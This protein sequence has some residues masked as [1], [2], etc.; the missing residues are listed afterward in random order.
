MVVVVVAV[1]AGVAVMM[2]V[3]MA[4]LWQ[5]AAVVLRGHGRGVGLGR[6]L[7]HELEHKTATDQ[8]EA[9]PP[10]NQNRSSS[11]VTLDIINKTDGRDLTLR[12]DTLPRVRPFP[13]GSCP[14]LWAP[15]ARWVA[16]GL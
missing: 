11:R 6:W 13:V 9:R 15:A 1:V 12:R 3:V 16:G 8:W 2:A 4:E 14:P 5:A 7:H 10:A